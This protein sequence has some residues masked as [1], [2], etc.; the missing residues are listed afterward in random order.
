MLETDMKSKKREKRK[1][2]KHFKF[3][4]S[5]AR[6]LLRECV[7]GKKWNLVISLHKQDAKEYG[8]VAGLYVD[9][10]FWEKSWTLTT[11]IN[12]S[13]RGEYYKIRKASSANGNGLNVEIGIGTD[14]LEKFRFFNR[15]YL[16]WRRL[17]IPEK[18]EQRDVIIAPGDDVNTLRLCYE[19]EINNSVIED[20]IKHHYSMQEANRKDEIIKQHANGFHA[21]E[22]R[23]FEQEIEYTPD[24]PEEE[25]ELVQEDSE[26]LAKARYYFAIGQA[27][28]D[29]YVN[30]DNIRRK[31]LDRSR[32]TDTR[33]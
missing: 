14:I 20:R 5:R 24:P 23:Q 22:P 21:P 16:L 29:F 19:M 6:L 15:T 32:Q 30:L 12:S 1:G 2:E 27:K 33:G 31:K 25:E 3:V 9:L 4:H 26:E 18:R 8:W 7:P 28:Y 13:G 11:C 17:D 10:K